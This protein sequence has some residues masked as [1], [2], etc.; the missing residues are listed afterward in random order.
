MTITPKNWSEFQHYK[1]RAPTWI[2]LHRSLLD[3]ADYY[4]LS[5]LAGKMLPLIWLIA[6]EKNGLLPEAPQLAWRLRIT[7]KQCLEILEDL[8]TREFLIEA[9]TETAGTSEQAATQA[10][11][12]AES[13]GFGNRHIADAVKREVWERDGGKCCQCASLEDIEYDHK[14]PVSKG[15]NSNVENIQLLCRPCNRSKRVKLATQA[16]GSR[17]LENKREKKEED[18]K[19]KNKMSDRN[20]TERKRRGYPKEFEEFWAAYP[21]LKG[22]SKTEAGASWGRLSPE[23]RSAALAALPDYKQFLAANPW[24][25]VQHACRFLSKRRFEGFAAEPDR[26][27]VI[28]EAEERMTR[29]RLEKANGSATTD[30]SDHETKL[31]SA[32]TA[33]H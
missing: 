9:D 17:S 7:E 5:P 16:L 31:L 19:E 12:V 3:N 32:G 15:G 11:Q 10:Q 13:N 21:P 22:M 8:F 28:R 14:V 30:G 2:K 26:R 25:H 33:V 18:K 1:D 24:Q 20:P 4:F 29:E 6:S 27:A 23:E